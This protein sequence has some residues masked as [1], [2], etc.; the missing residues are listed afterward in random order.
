MKMEPT[1]Y[2][3]HVDIN[4]ERVGDPGVINEIT[5]QFKLSS[6]VKKL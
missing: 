2:H 5:K 4:I 1:T 3:V 6:D